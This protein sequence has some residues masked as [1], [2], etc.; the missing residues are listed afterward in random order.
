MIADRKCK[1][2]PGDQNAEEIIRLQ[3]KMLSFQ[4][5]GWRAGDE[6]YPA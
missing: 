3:G 2:A 6:W 5:I 1:E 4:R